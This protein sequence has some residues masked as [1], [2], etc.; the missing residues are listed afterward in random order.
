MDMNIVIKQ[1]DRFVKGIK[2]CYLLIFI[3]FFVNGCHKDDTGPSD[4]K[5]LVEFKQENLFL[6]QAIETMLSPLEIEYPEA[7]GIK[8]NADY[9]VQI[10]SIIYKT[11]FKG[12]EIEAS[13]L[14]CVPFAGGTFPIISFQ[15]GTLTLHANAPTVNPLNFNYMVLEAMAS[16]G[17]I[18]LIPDNIGFG[19]SSGEVHPYYHKESNSTAIIDMIY[20]TKEMLEDKSI[21]AKGNDKYYLMGY[22]QGGWSTL[23]VL[24]ELENRGTPDISV[25]AASCGAGAYDLISM[26]EYITGITIFPS[27]LYMPYFIY[28]QQVYGSIADPLVKFFNEPYAS[29]I[30]EL[31]DG[32]H[33]NG[34][35][36]AGLND[37]ISRLLTPDL[38][39]NLLTG[40]DYQELRDVLT[41]NSITAW[42]AEA[43][44]RLYHG[45]EDLNVPPVQSRNMNDNFLSA[46]MD[47]SRI[48]L[49]D[50]TGL[51]HENGVVPWGIKTINWFNEL[52]GK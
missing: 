8:E 52:E 48:D 25:S 38:I 24:G 41:D 40:A 36:N 12:E 13:G 9:S 43:L 29:I 16:N 3:L 45:T 7:T 15:N 22:S 21:S 42:P 11:H 37:T 49:L 5:Y 10:F 17:Y 4:N 18:I 23:S 47:P 50:L 39:A 32:T 26:A 35:V 14:V 44:I 27:P 34:E 31:F 1:P 20:A 6:L 51:T 2:S 30:P 46:G 33:S 19:S 28:S